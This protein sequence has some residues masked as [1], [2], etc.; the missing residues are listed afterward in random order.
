MEDHEAFDTLSREYAEALDALH[1]IQGRVELF[2]T[3]GNDDALTLFVDDF[4][5][6]SAASAARARAAGLDELA[7]W[8]DEL[9]TEAQKCLHEHSVGRQEPR[10]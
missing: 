1:A 2:S 4:T 9:V 6:L 8:F 7:V 10:Q 3:N 5:R